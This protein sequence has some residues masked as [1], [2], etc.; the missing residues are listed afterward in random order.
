MIDGSARIVLR[1]RKHLKLC[2]LVN[3][4]IIPS[5]STPLPLHTNTTPPEQPDVVNTQP[6]PN[7]IHEN[8]TA[9]AS[10]KAPRTLKNI[11]D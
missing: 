10:A 3:P 8:L 9:T 1:N 11:A 7:I 5:A 4:S 6:N 2:H